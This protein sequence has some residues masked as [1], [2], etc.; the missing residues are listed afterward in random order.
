[1]SL[2]LAALLKDSSSTVS[3]NPYVFDA[4][5]RLPQVD[6]A[7][8]AS[9]K[10]GTVL[11]LK[12]S[13]SIIVI[14]HSQS[15]ESLCVQQTRPAKK[16][17]A[18]CASIAYCASGIT[19][20]SQYLSTKMFEKVS[21]HLYMFGS[22]PS[23]YRLSK[24]AADLLRMRT[25]TNHRPLGIR[26]LF[27]GCNNSHNKKKN[28]VLIEVDPIGNIHDCKLSSLGNV[29]TRNADCSRAINHLLFFN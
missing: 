24:E 29:H 1:M 25:L 8:E 22:D 12:G 7:F 16:V 9:S 3:L 17:R 11:A 4:H 21:D 19:T 2:S 27:L 26:A 23:I 15:D 28:L 10:G 13:E 14:T 6:A 18:L 20:D 5:G